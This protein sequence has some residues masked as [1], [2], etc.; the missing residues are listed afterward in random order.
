MRTG[1]KQSSRHEKTAH[2]LIVEREAEQLMRMV[3]PIENDWLRCT[4]SG[5]DVDG[6]GERMMCGGVQP[7][8]NNE[9]QASKFRSI[10]ATH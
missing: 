6:S 1:V 3:E 10:G 5:G 7:K 9:E 2:C 8:Q 4:M